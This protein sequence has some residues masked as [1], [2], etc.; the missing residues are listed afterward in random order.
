MEITLKNNWDFPI[1]FPYAK[2]KIKGLF[3]GRKKELSFLVNEL[4]RRET[5]SILVCGHRGV[6][7][8]SFVHKAIWEL[9]KK[10]S[11]II[12]ILLNAAQLEAESIKDNIEAKK[13]LENLIRRLYSM[14]RDVDSLDDGVNSLITDLYYK[15]VASNY[16]KSETL[17]LRTQF[18]DE[19]IK[20]KITSVKLAL[21]GLR[22]LL[23]L[24]PWL[25]S[26]FLILTK[27]IPI[28]LLNDFIALIIGLPLP[29]SLNYAYSKN[30]TIKNL[31]SEDRKSELLYKFDA[32]IG[33]IEYDLEKIHREVREKNQKLI[34]IIDE[35]DKLKPNQVVEVLKFFKNLFT[36]SD[37]LFIFIGGEEIFDLEGVISQNQSNIYRAKEYTYFTSKYFLS[38]PNWSALNDYFDHIVLDTSGSG[39]NTLSILKN[40]LFF[41]AKNDFFD[42]KSFI[43]SRIVDFDEEDNP[44]VFFEE[45]D[46]DIQK[47]RFY[48]SV[49]IIFEEKYISR[50]FNEWKN[51]EILLRQLF[52]HAHY[53]FNLNPNQPV[54]DPPDE[55][56]NAEI[57]RDF[58]SLLYRLE[59]FIYTKEE[60]KMI[61]GFQ[62]PIKTY[63]YVGKIPKDPPEKLDELT[64]FEQRYLQVFENFKD[65]LLPLYN[66]KRKI[67]GEKLIESKI[68]NSSPYSYSKELIEWQYNPS[69]I[70]EE[71]FAIYNT[72]KNETPPFKFRRENIETKTKQI[73]GQNDALFNNFNNTLSQGILKIY[74]GY[75]LKILQLQSDRNFFT[76]SDLREL[77]SV[78][79]NSNPFV[80][81]TNDY[82]RQI[83][84]TH[85]H[86]EDIEEFKE[87]IENN[88]E[89]YK[90]ISIIKENK[91]NIKIRGLSIISFESA[92]CL[93]NSLI[94]LFDILPKFLEKPEQN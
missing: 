80:V 50:R 7:K 9:K 55:T 59:A 63:Q 10:D 12:P 57:I 37:A 46:E 13:I 32:S 34:Y 29:L 24:I 53:V 21:K 25:T 23:F 85:N 52:K 20:Q 45:N 93:Y 65:F 61:R 39:Y 77:K 76:T 48:R 70:S 2:S 64:E 42:L 44:I 94:E 72:L 69:T 82:S 86:I 26:L 75:N 22:A 28:E 6:G 83:L 62:T 90:F 74:P 51:N 5:G 11:T 68:Y 41:E 19:V 54:V 3:L 78:F 79:V 18:S 33:N 8:T 17:S 16:E 43:K 67:K 36:L 71:N 58:N 56:I 92:E 88:S 66:A 91:R 84:V 60:T 30:K 38:R 1:R 73:L 81:S 40:A 27:V 35:L 15:T 31:T 14:T 87:I 47:N 89:R 49:L 4:K